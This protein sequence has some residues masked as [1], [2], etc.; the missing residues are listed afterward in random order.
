MIVINWNILF[1]AV[2]NYQ[3]LFLFRLICKDVVQNNKT[4]SYWHVKTW[5][6]WFT[7]NSDID[8]V[9]INFN[10]KIFSWLCKWTVYIY[11]L[12]W[13]IFHLYAI[14]A[15]VILQ[16]VVKGVELIMTG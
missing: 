8:I 9:W 16:Q 14:A 4:V 7:I 3:D 2:T 5:Q 12:S 6:Y 15:D 1:R 13:S 10:M 11:F